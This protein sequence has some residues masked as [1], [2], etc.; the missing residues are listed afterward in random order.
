MEVAYC[1]TK[2]GIESLMHSLCW[3]TRAPHRV[4]SSATSTVSYWGALAT[5]RR[6]LRPS[7]SSPPRRRVM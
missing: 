1:P 7:P 5:L 2:S 6:S 3:C 4:Y